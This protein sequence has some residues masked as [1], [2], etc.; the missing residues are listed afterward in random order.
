MKK[1]ILYKDQILLSLEEENE[2]LKAYREEK[3][4]IG[5]GYDEEDYIRASID[6]W[7]NFFSEEASSIMKGKEYI[8][9]GTLGLWNGRK[10]IIPTK[11]KGFETIIRCIGD[12][13]D[14]EIIDNDGRLI[15]LAHH[16]DGVNRFEIR[17]ARYNKKP[18]L[19][20]TLGYR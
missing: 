15:I 1:I 6:D 10:E 14:C 3:E 18:R 8:I 5:E 16:H 13:Y 4:L 11:A 7:W 20:Q 17:E 12:C 2:M 19:A 9:K